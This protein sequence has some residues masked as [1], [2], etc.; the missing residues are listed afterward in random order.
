M[1]TRIPPTATIIRV[2]LALVFLA[3]ALTAIFMPDEFIGLLEGSFVGSALPTKRGGYYQS[4]CRQR[5][6]GGRSA[7]FKHRQEMA[8]CLGR[9]M[10]IRGY[11]CN[12]QTC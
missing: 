9:T 5:Y 12:R 6:P 7:V 10:D 1:S 3:N 11:G 8:I 4:D 2:G